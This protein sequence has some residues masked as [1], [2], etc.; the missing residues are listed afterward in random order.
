MM[1]S[2]K[3]ASPKPTGAAA[4]REPKTHRRRL[5]CSWRGHTK[6]VA[7]TSIF[8]IMARLSE[9]T[10]C[11]DHASIFGLWPYWNESLRLR[12]GNIR[13]IHCLS[14]LCMFKS[15]VGI[16][17]V[18]DW[19]ASNCYAH[20]VTHFLDFLHFSPSA[21]A[22]HS[23]ES[24][25]LLSTSQSPNLRGPNFPSLLASNSKCKHRLSTS[26]IISSSC[27]KSCAADK[28]YCLTRRSSLQTTCKHAVNRQPWFPRD[29]LVETALALLVL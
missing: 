10:N 12:R 27:N 13:D 11:E 28:E 26:H 21:L 6:Y 16:R 1:H 3:S 17:L 24:P 29:R 23:H 8:R 25:W 22:Q 9:S 15:C 4:R 19:T 18:Q 2:C 20:C 14:W 7:H 5:S